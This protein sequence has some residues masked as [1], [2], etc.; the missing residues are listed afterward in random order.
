MARL[1]RLVLPGLAHLVSLDAHDGRLPFAL[2]DDC[3][4]FL[5]ML[6]EACTIEAVTGVAYAFSEKSVHLV[7][8]PSTLTGL[9]AVMQAVGRR[10]VSGF[11][12]RHGLHGTLWKGRFR[13]SALEPGRWTL[14]ALVWVDGLPGA[15]GWSS[16]AMRSSGESRPGWSHPP[17]YWALGNTPFERE[18]RFRQMLE[19]GCSEATG[20]ALLAGLSGGWPVGSPEFIGTLSGSISRPSAP[21]RPGRPRRSV[22]PG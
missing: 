12:R 11:N 9:S 5:D 13:A 20:R 14:A 15:A 2:A 10:F 4:A 18:A 17:E 22:V 3:M 1:P 16:A 7:L 8:R 6:R 21:R 19:E